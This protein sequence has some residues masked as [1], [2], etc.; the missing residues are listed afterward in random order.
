ML[1]E[2]FPKAL[3][4]PGR[5]IHSLSLI[6]WV[7]HLVIKSDQLGQGGLAFP[8]PMLDPSDPLVVLYVLCGCTQDHLFHNLPEHQGQSDRPEISQV[9]S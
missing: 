5:H 1:W 3:L 4:G 8:K 2:T 7:G 6:L 9:R